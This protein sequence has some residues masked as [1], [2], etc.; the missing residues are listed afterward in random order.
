MLLA[1][2][3]GI[4]GATCVRAAG[5]AG[6][7]D[8]VGAEQLR[9]ALLLLT[10]PA[11]LAQHQWFGQGAQSHQIRLDRGD[12]V[13]GGHPVGPGPQLADGLRP[14]QQQHPY[15]RQLLVVE[16]QPLVEHLPVAQHRAPVRGVHEADQARL[17]ERGQGLFHH[18]VAV[19]NHRIA[20]RRLIAGQH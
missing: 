8:G 12:P 16:G 19:A 15:Q 1:A 9:P 2:S 17:L 13:E 20:V 6:R 14:A 10:G 7:P 3:C 4:D 5:C 18:P 11:R